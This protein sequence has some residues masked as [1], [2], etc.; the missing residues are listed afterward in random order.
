MT[1]VRG[2]TEPVY[3]VIERRQGKASAAIY[4]DRLPAKGFEYALRLDKLAFGSAWARMGMPELLAV[5]ERL[6]ARGEL[7]PSNLA[8]AKPK[9]D[10]A[11]KLTKHGDYWTPPAKTWDDRAPDQVTAAHERLLR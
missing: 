1:E 9:A 2:K 4:H 6:K 7:P 8:D 3:L 5:Y 11:P 10:S